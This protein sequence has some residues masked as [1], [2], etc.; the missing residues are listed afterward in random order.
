[1]IELVTCDRPDQKQEFWSTFNPQ[2]QTWVVADLQS[3]LSLQKHILAKYGAFEEDAVLRATELWRKLA[4]QVR[5]ELRILSPELAHSLIW[6]WIQ[7]LKLSF[8]RTPQAVPVVLNQ[9]QMWM[10]LYA[11]G[12]NIEI[13]AGW[14]RDHPESYVRW[15]HWFELGLSLWRRCQ[16]ENLVLTSWLPAL[17]LGQDLSSMVWPKQ[18]ILD[19]GPRMTPVEGQLLRELS[20]GHDLRVIVPEVPWSDLMPHTLRAYEEL[21]WSLQKSGPSWVP[22]VSEPVEFGRFST[23]LAEV[24]D[25]VAAVR[26]WLDAGVLPENVT[27]LAPDIESYWPLLRMYLAEEGIPV[28]K[29]DTARLGSFLEVAQWM[30]KLRTTL[31]QVRTSDLEMTLFAQTSLPR[32]SYDDFKVLFTQVYEDADLNRARELFEDALEWDPQ[33]PV[34]ILEFLTW[35][36]AYWP[37]ANARWDQLLK[38]LGQEVPPHLRMRA[39]A[40]LSYLQGL[41]ARRESKLSDGDPKGVSCLSLSSSE[42]VSATHGVVLNMSESALHNRDVSPVTGRESQRVLQDTGFAVGTT[43]RQEMEFELLWLLQ[44]PWQSLRLTFSTTDFQGQVLTPSRFWMWAGFT[45]GKLKLEGESPRATRWDEI[46]RRSDHDIASVRGFS[47]TR[48][49]NVRAGLQRDW[50]ATPTNWQRLTSV[51]LSA[52]SLERYWSCPFAFAAEKALGLRDPSVLD[53]DLDARTRGSLIHAILE[54]VIAEPFNGHLSDEELVARIDS[55]REKAQIRLGDE[56]LW[57]AIRNQYLQKTKEVLRFEVDWRKR[58]PAT[59]TLARELD[60]SVYWDLAQGEVGR[61]ETPV[62]IS[63]RVDRVDVDSQGRYALI[64]YKSSGSGL[65]NWNRWL[66]NASIQMP[67]YAILIESGLLNVPE[68]PVMAANYF[69]LKALHR[70]KGFQVRDATSELYDNAESARHF[71][72]LEQKQK[73]FLEAK[74]KISLTIQQI[75][76][77][78]FL[79]I[80]KKISTCGTCP[81]SQLC[82][83]PHLN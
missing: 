13:M 20:R 73:L 57:P 54:E 53:L 31:R 5:P 51:R 59:K 82:R 35:A 7:P 40:W 12:E 67:L 1:M 44:R 80:P 68:G 22:H 10:S 50:L 74:E 37:K 15:G 46:Q 41:L 21:G 4:F 56:R 9:M 18:M 28:A 42:G 14:F 61:A 63:G 75:L 19:L 78:E 49:S 83:A 65:T 76:N 43:D 45:S 27:I 38:I 3:K 71:I 81:W 58:F 48:Q 29:A 16:D 39:D 47:A 66:D 34:T 26:G 24:K 2:S 33:Q 72:D 23:Q 79:P 64:D 70:K 8:A 11:R 60:F 32:L 30:S 17:M 25:A 62:R 52:S 36:M 69:N 6:S 77:A 55:A